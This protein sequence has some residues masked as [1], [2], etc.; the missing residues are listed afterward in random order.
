MGEVEFDADAFDGIDEAADVAQ[1]ATEVATEEAAEATETAT[2]TS[3]ISVRDI[4]GKLLTADEH[5]PRAGTLR[6]AGI[7]NGAE[8]IG[9]GLTDWILEV[10]DVELGDTL[11]PLGKMARGVSQMLSNADVDETED[12]SESE[13]IEDPAEQLAPTGGPT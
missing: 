11:G 3:Q 13:T 1:E 8:H 9:D 6:E 10:V 2:S 4:L 12:E 5:G 7:E